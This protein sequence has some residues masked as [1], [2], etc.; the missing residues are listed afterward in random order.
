MP[1]NTRLDQGLSLVLLDDMTT[2]VIQ[3]YCYITSGLGCISLSLP[4]QESGQ[5]STINNPFQASLVYSL[6]EIQGISLGFSTQQE[7]ISPSGPASS[8]SGGSSG[9]YVKRLFS[10]Q[11]RSMRS[12]RRLKAKVLNTTGAE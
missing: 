2:P 7:D 11:Q 10:P 4:R 12:D 6:Q 1:K 8:F 3:L 9:V 5:R